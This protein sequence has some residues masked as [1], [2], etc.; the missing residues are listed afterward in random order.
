M[1]IAEDA[2]FGVRA[3]AIVLGW[4]S[5]GDTLEKGSPSKR[6]RHTTKGK[7][8]RLKPQPVASLLP[9]S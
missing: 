7:L 3:L 9:E 5:I 8:V 2:V 4:L 6:G 1:C